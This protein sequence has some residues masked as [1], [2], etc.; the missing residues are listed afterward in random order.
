MLNVKAIAISHSSVSIQE[1][2]N[3][4]LEG[5]SSESIMISSYFNSLN[6]KGQEFFL[7][8]LDT[9]EGYCVQ[10]D[11]S[12]VKDRVKTRKLRKQVSTVAK[13]TKTKKSFIRHVGGLFKTSLYEVLEFRAKQLLQ[14]V[15]ITPTE[16]PILELMAIPLQE[17]GFIFNTV[18][19][20]S[21]VKCVLNLA[22]QVLAA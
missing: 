6:R 12:V 3:G 4:L 21:E 13:R 11:A 14:R 10:E 18:S 17:A 19:L 1:V 20:S 9:L 7:S 5:L 22:A 15:G 16:T 8:C 2:F